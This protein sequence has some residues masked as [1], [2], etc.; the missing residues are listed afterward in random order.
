MKID[1]LKND[2]MKALKCLYIAV[3]SSIADDVNVKVKAYIDALTRSSFDAG[4]KAMKVEC[5]NKIKKVKLKYYRNKDLKLGSLYIN[6]TEAI[7][8]I[9]GATVKFGK[10][11]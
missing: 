5:K 10:R 1:E 9:Q 4:A 2:C 7:A 8:A 6:C 11:V 3:E